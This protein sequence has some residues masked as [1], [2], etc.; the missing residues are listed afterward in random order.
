M[1]I[2]KDSGIT[3]PKGFKAAGI[4]CGIKKK[5]KDF[6][7]KNKNSAFI[8]NNEEE[9]YDVTVSKSGTFKNLRRKFKIFKQPNK[10]N[11]YK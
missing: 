2:L 1:K 9:F 3:A 10:S 5:K 11:Y 4:H 7:V 6:V 8:V